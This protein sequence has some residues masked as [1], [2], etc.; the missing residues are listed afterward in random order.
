MLHYPINRHGSCKLFPHHRHHSAAP[1]SQVQTVQPWKAH[2]SQWKAH[3]HK[4]PSLCFV[5]ADPNH[6]RTWVRN[7]GPNPTKPPL[8]VKE[9]E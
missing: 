8:P 2:A 6:T 1:T 3:G 7:E 9:E 4:A 5:G